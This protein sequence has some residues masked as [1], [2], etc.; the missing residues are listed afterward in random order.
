MLPQP[1]TARRPPPTARRSPLAACR[2]PLAA[3]RRPRTTAVTSDVAA[4]DQPARL[5]PRYQAPR[6]GHCGGRVDVPGA[7]SCAQAAT[8]T[9]PWR[10][11]PARKPLGEPQ[12]W[13]FAL[14]LRACNQEWFVSTDS[15]P[16]RNRRSLR[17]G[18]SCKSAPTSARPSPGKALGRWWSSCASRSSAPTSSSSTRCAAAARVHVA[19]ARGTDCRNPAPPHIKAP[20]FTSRP[21]NAG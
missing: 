3:C 6:D 12:H 4:P 14:G 11:A 2:S 18:T 8:G 20:F 5:H 21:S 16:Q 1:P 15:A 7:S 10:H 17:S 13:P 9:Q 19:P